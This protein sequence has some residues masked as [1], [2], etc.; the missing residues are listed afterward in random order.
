MDK[1]KTTQTFSAD[2]NVC[3]DIEQLKECIIRKCERLAG[4]MQ[5][6]EALQRRISNTQQDIEAL[7]SFLHYASRF[8]NNGGARIH[9]AH[10]DIPRFFKRASRMYDH[11]CHRMRCPINYACFCTAIHARYELEGDPHRKGSVSL[12]ISTVITYFK[13]E[14]E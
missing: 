9:I 8:T 5:Q 12:S 4:Q 6:L 2:I 10:A 3:T 14:R 1:M 11:L 13:R 7:S